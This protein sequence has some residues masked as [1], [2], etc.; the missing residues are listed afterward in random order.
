E[1]GHGATDGGGLG[2]G[3]G[4]GG[5]GAKKVRGVGGGG[6]GVVGEEGGG[7]GPHPPLRDGQRLR[8]GHSALPGRRAGAGWSAIGKLSLAEVFAATQTAGACV[9]H[10]RTRAGC[11]HCGHHDRTVPSPCR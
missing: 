9:G 8:N 4:K 11:R 10:Y 6:G 3:G 1:G 7:E 2:G 5:W